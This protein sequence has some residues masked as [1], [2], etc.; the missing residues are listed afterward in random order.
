MTGRVAHGR[1]FIF[2][3]SDLARQRHIQEPASLPE[4][5]ILES[6]SKDCL[7][8]DRLAAEGTCHAPELEP[9]LAHC[10]RITHAH[11]AVAPGGPFASNSSRAC[12]QNASRPSVWSL[13]LGESVFI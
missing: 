3:F 2:W 1:P 12:E 11:F 7:K 13:S 5:F 10:Y 6:S 9:N 8:N 4:S